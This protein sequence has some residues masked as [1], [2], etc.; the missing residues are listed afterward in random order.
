MTDDKRVDEDWKER[1]ELEKTAQPK[2]EPPAPAAASA[3]RK[4]RAG[5]GRTRPGE[6]AAMDFQLFLSS[7]SMQAM[8]ALGEL[9]SEATGQPQQ[10]LDQ[11]RWL[12]DAIGLL[13][14][15][16]QGNLTA[17]EASL[18]EGVLYELRMKYV[19]KTG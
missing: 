3:G 16:T 14:E 13:Q 19:E 1:V 7:L 15:K 12:I 9:P 5:E 18:M 11:A 6:P 17:E 8:A 4:E 2:P 10:N